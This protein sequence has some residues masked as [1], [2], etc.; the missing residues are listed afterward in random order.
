MVISILW[1]SFILLLG[2]WWAR[3]VISQARSIA[4][5]EQASGITQQQVQKKLTKKKSMILWELGAFFFIIMALSLIQFWIFFQSIRR[6]KSLQAFFAS[7]THELRTPLTSIRLQTEAITMMMPPNSGVDHLFQRLQEDTNRLESQVEKALELTRIEG[8]GGVHCSEIDFSSWIDHFLSRIASST[9]TKARIHHQVENKS[10]ALDAFA[11]EIIFKNLIENSIK[12]SGQQPVDIQISA[13]ANE[14]KYRVTYKD[15]GHKKNISQPKL[16]TIFE[17]GVESKGAG[18][19]L[20]LVA[21]L[22]KKMGGQARF[23][24]DQGFNAEL[25]FYLG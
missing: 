10:I 16:G 11:L 21:S 1:L 3:V 23:S 24:F 25:M 8:G 6:T 13:Q 17:K 18:I 7:V 2:G 14:N 20:Y 4:Q 19:G 12:H 9:A 5:L 22:T 15:N